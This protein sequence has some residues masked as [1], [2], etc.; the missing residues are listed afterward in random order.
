MQKM[1]SIEVDETVNQI[2]NSFYRLGLWHAG[3]ETTRKETAR[4]LFFSIYT[5]LLPISLLS[6][7]SLTVERLEDSLFLIE[8]A[9]MTVI[10]SVKLFYIIWR[11]DE[12]L[13]ML[14]RIGMYSTKHASESKRINGKLNHFMS[15]MKIFFSCSVL[16]AICALL[17]VPFLGSEKKLF[18]NIGFP[19][20]WQHSE[21]AY[22]IAFTFILTEVILSA[23]SVLFSIIVWYLFL[24]CSLRFQLLGHDL[25]SMGVIEEVVD[26][27]GKKRKVSKL[28]MEN[29]FS[30]D[31]VAAVKSHREIIE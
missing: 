13:Q 24:N 3:E 17:I 23:I 25:R 15:L 28:E 26:S 19:L 8:A 22:W 6:G 21:F 10:M 4:K 29:Q 20:D 12:I 18:F 5:V 9:I 2:K 7:V 14:D 1:F 11:K 31:L 27:S 16:I 30:K